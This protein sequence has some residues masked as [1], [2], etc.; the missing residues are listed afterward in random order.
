MIQVILAGCHVLV[1]ELLIGSGTDQNERSGVAD[2]GLDHI[3]DASGSVIA[4]E[5]QLVRMVRET[6]RGQLGRRIRHNDSA[7]GV[8]GVETESVVLIRRRIDAAW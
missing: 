6:G 2:L 1:R 3:S 7:D 5:R 8:R 4:L